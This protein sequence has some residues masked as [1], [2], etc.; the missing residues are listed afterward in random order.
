MLARLNHAV[1][2]LTAPRDRRLLGPLRRS[3]DP[4]RARAP[5]AQG[6]EFNKEIVSVVEHT[7]SG[8]RKVRAQAADASQAAR[9]MLGKT[10]E[11]ARRAE[12]S[13][14]AMR[15]AAQTAAA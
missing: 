2:A 11:V 6:S 14:V 5:P 9:G 3:P 4:R 15:E 1:I 7:A 8:S 10:S 12:Q 13:A